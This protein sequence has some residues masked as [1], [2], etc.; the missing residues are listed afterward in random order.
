MIEYLN[1]AYP[2]AENVIKFAVKKMSMGYYNKKVLEVISS[3]LDLLL[4]MIR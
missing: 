4:K 2:P 3:L 1:P